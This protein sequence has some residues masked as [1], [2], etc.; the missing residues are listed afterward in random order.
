MKNIVPVSW[1]AFLLLILAAAD[2]ALAD[3]TFILGRQIRG[4]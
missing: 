1:T 3:D 2:A 4:T